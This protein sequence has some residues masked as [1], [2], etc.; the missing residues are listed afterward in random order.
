MEGQRSIGA[1]DTGFQGVSLSEGFGLSSDEQLITA[2]FGHALLD[3]W[4][5]SHPNGGIAHPTF[6]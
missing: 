1:Y 2:N 6:G 3:L 4:G 5:V